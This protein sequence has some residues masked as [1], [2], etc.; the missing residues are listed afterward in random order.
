MWFFVGLLY[1]CVFVLMLRV[2]KLEDQMRQIKSGLPP[3]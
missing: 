2:E 3:A 1:A